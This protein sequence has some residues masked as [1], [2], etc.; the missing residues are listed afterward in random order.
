MLLAYRLASISLMA[1]LAS[2]VWHHSP[3]VHFG[4]ALPVLYRI[5]IAALS[6]SETMDTKRS[7]IRTFPEACE[8]IVRLTHQDHKQLK[9]YNHS[10]DRIL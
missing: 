8:R 4:V 6:V 1:A 2:W 9:D 7:T 10:L 5:Y 3:P